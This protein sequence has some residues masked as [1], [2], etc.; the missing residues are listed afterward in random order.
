MLGLASQRAARCAADK[1]HFELRAALGAQRMSNENTLS[2]R[3]LFMKLGI[4]LQRFGRIRAGVVP[5]VGFVLSSITR[6]R[7]NAYLLVGS[8]WVSK[9]ISRRRDTAG[10]TFRNPNVM[11]TDG[12]TVDTACWVRRMEE[13]AVPGFCRQLCTSWLPR[14]VVFRASPVSSCVLAMAEPTTA[15]A[16]EPRVRRS[17]GSSSIPT[18]CKTGLSPFRRANCTLRERVHR[19]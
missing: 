13:G 4:L 11:P 8:S 17:V 18:K 15:M 3:G 10:R 6:G 5:V 9:R 16:H 2:R 14:P 12:K 1:F 7:S 19:L